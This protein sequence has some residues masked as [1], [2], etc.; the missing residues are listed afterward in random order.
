[1]N[2]SILSIHRHDSRMAMISSGVLSTARLCASSDSSCC[3]PTI[4]SPRALRVCFFGNAGS[5][6]TD[7]KLQK[8]ANSGNTAAENEVGIRYRLGKT[9][10][11]IRRRRSS[12]F[13][14]AAKQGY[15]K[16]T[17][18]SARNYNGDGVNVNDQYACVWFT[19][20][21]DAGNSAVK[22]PSHAR[23]GIHLGADDALRGLTA[24]AYRPAR[25]SNRITANSWS[26]T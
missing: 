26:C 10:T 18:I 7:R 12:E 5:E 2:T 16:G 9:S 11:K 19:L 21:A 22:R 6:A 4:I 24:T 20:A 23:S 17:S 14:K 13:A 3:E 1:M 15:A 25:G 8:L